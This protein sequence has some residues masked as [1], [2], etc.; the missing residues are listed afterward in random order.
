M[1]SV[2]VEQTEIGYYV[3]SKSE[4][5]VYVGACTE[6]S[7]LVVSNSVVFIRIPRCDEKFDGSSVSDGSILRQY[8]GVVEVVN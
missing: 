8:A 2:Q 6:S 5:S 3:Y 4:L 7:E 1:P